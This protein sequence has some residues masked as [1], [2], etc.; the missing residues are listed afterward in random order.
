MLKKGVFA[1]SG[2]ALSAPYCAP[3]VAFVRYGA[4]A[5][6]RGRLQRRKKKRMS[7][8]LQK[9]ASSLITFRDDVL[10]CH[11]LPQKILKIRDDEVFCQFY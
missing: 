2:D 5:V 8:S 6:L 10:Y 7:G 9:V 3:Y 11:F 4:C 1:L